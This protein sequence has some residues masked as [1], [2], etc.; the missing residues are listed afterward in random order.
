MDGLKGKIRMMALPL[1]FLASSACAASPPVASTAPVQARTD[2]LTIP[3][4]F[5]GRFVRM[6]GTPFS[7]MALRG[8][9]TKEGG[10]FLSRTDANGVAPWHWHS[11]IEEFV[12][13]TG[14]VV[15]QVKGHAPVALSP[16]GYS[17]APGKVP[18]R[19]RCIGNQDCILLTIGAGAY[20]MHWV[21]EHGNELTSEQALSRPNEIGKTW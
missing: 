21:D 19:F 13:L 2:I 16:G 15:V 11:P 8:D 20:D 3:N 14:N 7:N 1:A 5:E 9:L 4:P 10:T 18:H 12:V 6:E 17:Q